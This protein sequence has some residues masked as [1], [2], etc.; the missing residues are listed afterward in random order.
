[1]QHLC[2]LYRGDEPASVQLR[3]ALHEVAVAHGIG[4]WSDIRATNPGFRLELEQYLGGADVILQC[5]GKKGTGLYQDLVEVSAT[6]N[7]MI[8]RTDRRLVII[9]LDGTSSPP[10]LGKLEV[11]RSRTKILQLACLQRWARSPL[12]LHY[13]VAEFTDSLCKLKNR[14]EDSKMTDVPIGWHPPSDLILSR[15]PR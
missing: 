8:A 14:P 2:F 3:D 11:F 15:A 1:V 12:N 4:F 7:A 5:V 9:L 13:V 6:Y 10:Q